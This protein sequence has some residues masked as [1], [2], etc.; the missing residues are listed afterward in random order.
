M[1]SLDLGC[2]TKITN[3]KSITICH[4]QTNCLATISN[5][6]ISLGFP[7]GADSIFLDKNG[8][9]LLNRDV[10]FSICTPVAPADRSGCDIIIEAGQAVP[11]QATL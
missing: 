5:S 6:A 10:D 4:G 1:D 11:P 3:T 2:N 8:C 7:A 9:L